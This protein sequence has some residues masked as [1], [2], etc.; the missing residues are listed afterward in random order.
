M[1]GI[2]WERMTP[3]GVRGGPKRA[4]APRGR[5]ILAHFDQRRQKSLRFGWKTALECGRRGQ[6]GMD[7]V[8]EVAVGPGR[9]HR[10]QDA[11]SS[12]RIDKGEM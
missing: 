11:T 12:A 2:G 8:H 7:G 4:S 5:N 10:L 1:W 3:D 9:P 6:M